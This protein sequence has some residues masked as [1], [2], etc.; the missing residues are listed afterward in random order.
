MEADTRWWW[1]AIDSSLEVVVVG[2]RMGVRGAQGDQVGIL[3]D[4]GLELLA[5]VTSLVDIH[6]RVAML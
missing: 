2:V 3:R 1:R 5:E 4:R 6:H